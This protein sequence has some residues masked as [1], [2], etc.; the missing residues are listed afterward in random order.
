MPSDNLMERILLYYSY[1]LSDYSKFFIVRSKDD[2]AV[3]SLDFCNL[4]TKIG[5][6]F[7][8]TKQSPDFL[9]ILKEMPL[10]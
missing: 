9:M 2:R 3:V 7:E 10:I 5:D 8:I 6:Y 4:P 1:K